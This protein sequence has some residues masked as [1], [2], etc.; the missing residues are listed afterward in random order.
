[1]LYLGGSNFDLRLKRGFLSTAL[2][3]EFDFATYEPRG[4][5]RT[6]HPSGTWRMADYAKDALSVLDALDWPDA[7]VIGESFGG[8]TALHL[9][10]LA[11]ERVTRLVVAAATAGG[12]QHQSYDISKLLSLPDEEAARATLFLQDARNTRLAE[13][14][15]QAFSQ[16][17][18]ER[19]GYNK[20]FANPSVENGG[21][22]RLLEARRGHDCTD[23]VASIQTPALVIAG[24]HDQQAPLVAQQALGDAMPNAV[25]KVFVAGHGVLFSDP[26]AF[27]SALKFLKERVAVSAST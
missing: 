16:K 10:L 19:L 11:P 24:K 20:E 2:I 22:A 25:C 23:L 15:P 13:T 21:Y 8:M 7:H 6:E 3:R 26:Q 18:S 4:I 9:A 27:D 14:D 5:G 12:P 17:V 1:M